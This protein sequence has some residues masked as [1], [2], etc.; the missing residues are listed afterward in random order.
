MAASRPHAA[1][2]GIRLVY[3]DLAAGA[4][5]VAVALDPATGLPEPASELSGSTAPLDNM[6]DFA[7]GWDTG[8]Q[9]HGRPAAIAFAPDGRM[10]VG[11]DWSGV[12]VW[13]APAG[14]MPP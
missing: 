10:F 13:M 4:R 9:N 8:M 1:A 3:D 2:L 11:D 12:I 14:L 5:V 7:T 6:L